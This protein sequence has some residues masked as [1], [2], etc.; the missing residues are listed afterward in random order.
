MAVASTHPVAFLRVLLV[1]G[2]VSNLPTVW[3]NCLAGWLLGGGGYDW[4]KFALLNLGATLLYLGGMYLNDA[5]DYFF[6]VQYR[7]DRPIPSGAI[8][9][10][11]VW[12]I[13]AGWLVIGLGV[14]MAL[15]WTTAVLAI[16]LVA[17]IVA[18]DVTH[19]W[20]CW[21]P[22]L[23]ALCRLFLY[24]TA[25]STAQAGV[26]GL[27]LWCAIA[28]ALYIV[29]LSY[30]A[31]KES[32]KGPLKT[33]PTYLLVIPIALA[34]LVN[35]GPYLS[36]AMIISLLL[37]AWIAWSVS[38]TFWKPEKDV[39]KTVSGLLAGIVLVDWLAVAG[40]GWPVTLV[41]LGFF[42]LAL[43]FQKFVPAT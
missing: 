18:Y 33:W 37:A 4:G 1:L 14:L 8:D 21:S 5:C 42:A 2:R 19:K 35:Q 23:M 17:C 16:C 12:W 25:A 6:D 40:G 28:L 38:H 15:G 20:I 9:L 32:A 7:R 24:L 11:T 36:W 31:R 30:L 10:K 39:G 26:T 34:L 3:S 22:W 43:I 13:S 41:M 29:G 27:A